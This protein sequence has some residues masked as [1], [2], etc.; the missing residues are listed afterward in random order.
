M[1]LNF[2]LTRSNLKQMS[3]KFHEKQECEMA[4]DILS[5]INEFRAYF[6]LSKAEWHSSIELREALNEFYITSMVRPMVCRLMS[7]DDVFNF[8]HAQTQVVVDHVFSLTHGISKYDLEAFFG[9]SSLILLHL[10]G[11]G[12]MSMPTG[13]GIFPPLDTLVRH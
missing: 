8:L 6:G 11:G 9:R 1:D 2:I 7:P 13:A 12:D 5:M 4:D 3:E 10:N